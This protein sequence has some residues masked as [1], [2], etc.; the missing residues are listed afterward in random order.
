LTDDSIAPEIAVVGRDYLEQ[1]GI[2][3]TEFGENWVTAAE[4]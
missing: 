4:T 1:W 2:G 3:L